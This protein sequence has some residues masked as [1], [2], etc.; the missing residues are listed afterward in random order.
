MIVIKEPRQFF[1]KLC[2]LFVLTI[3]LYAQTLDDPFHFDDAVTIVWNRA[4]HLLPDLSATVSGLAAFQPSRFVTNLTFALNYYAG[5]LDTRGY[6]A[7]N[8]LVHLGTACLVWWLGNLL[9]SLTHSS[10]RAKRSEAKQSYKHSKIASSAKDSLL[11]KTS[12]KLNT[13]FSIENSSNIPYLTALVFLAHPVNTQAVSYLNQRG[14]ALAAMFYLLSVCCYIKGRI[15]GG[16]QLKFFV[17]A[18]VSGLLASFSKETAITLPLMIMTVELFFFR[19]KNGAGPRRVL[20]ALLF[21]GFLVLIPAA[22]RFNYTEMLLREVPS[23]SHLGDVLTLPTYLLTQVRVFVTFLRLIFIPAGLNLDHDYPM[24]H[25]VGDPAFL[26]SA[27]VIAGILAGAYYTRQKH[28]MLTF[29]AVWFFLT[30]SSNLVPRAHVMFEHKLYL[31]LTGTLP[32]LVL[33]SLAFV[34][35]RRVMIAGLCCIIAIFSVLTFLRNR[36]WDSEITLWEDVLTK[37][38]DKARV[39]LSLGVAYAADGRFEDA[40]HLFTRVIERTSEPYR[41]YS[42]RGAVYVK[43]GRDDLALKDFNSAIASGPGFLDAYLN[44]GELFARKRDYN[45]ALADFDR[46]IAMDPQYAPAYR[47]RGRVYDAM[48]RYD[49][50]WADYNKALSIDPA[51]VQALAWRGY[52]QATAGRLDDAF[53]DFNAALRLDSDLSDA[54]VYRGMYY[55][56]K[57]QSEAAFKDLNKAL[58]LKPDS[59]LAHYQRAGL[60]LALGQTSEALRD[61]GQAIKLDDKFDLPYALRARIYADRKDYDLAMEDLNKA[62]ELDPYSFESFMN[63]GTL[64]MFLNNTLGAVDDFANAIRLNPSAASAYSQ[65]GGA[66]GHLKKYDLAVADF[67]KAIE[68]NPRQGAN[69]YN[70]SMIYHEAG[71]QSLALPDARKARELGFSVSDKYIERLKDSANRK[72]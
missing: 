48:R 49:K 20:F 9:V 36:V 45:S 31:A 7:V 23:Q 33:G 41:A 55:K 17:I 19:S 69:Y 59:A 38:P 1:L 52:L 29:A 10:L 12:I 32:A 27:C 66:Y 54:Y 25:S 14:E 42:N 43:M 11:A 15:S 18:V 47:M 68:L 62:L 16:R 70:R 65:R 35:D 64:K 34:K 39:H 56:E 40:L 67:S 44:R 37:S 5:G 30:L 46:V 51:D 2:V 72:D 58:S 22:F 24:V 28:P 8:I 57:R 50:A 3:A 61:L 60:F 53:E 71:E 26:G 6:H 13:I 63:R 4:A 21:L